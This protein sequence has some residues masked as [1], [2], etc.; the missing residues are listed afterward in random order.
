[1]NCAY[2]Y[3]ITNKLKNQII[4][5]GYT[6]TPEKRFKQ[7]ENSIKRK[8]HLPLYK[9][10]VKYGIE[11]FEFD[12]LY[13]GFDKE[14]TLRVMEPFFIDLFRTH[15]SEY[16]YNLCSGG[17]GSTKRPLSEN[18][19]KRIGEANSRRITTEK[20]KRLRSE[21]KKGKKHSEERKKRQSDWAKRNNIRPPM[22]EEIR[23]KLRVSHLGKSLHTEEEKQKRREKLLKDNPM[24]NS[25]SIKKANETKKKNKKMN[26]ARNPN[27]IKV[28]VYKDN[29]L[30]VKGYLTEICEQYN[31][32]YTT[33]YNNSR[34]DGPIEKGPNK[35]IDVV[36]V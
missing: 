12:V 31:I 20:T 28:V 3:T 34:K 18:T 15:I 22:T 13:C 5:I 23:K 16:G 6:A 14:H 27:A 17:S 21:A 30:L 2:I 26:G 35:G 24:N 8:Q 19:K 1:M 33:L 25:E 7:H 10:I 11:N 9:H 4:Y 29:S 36:R 32:K